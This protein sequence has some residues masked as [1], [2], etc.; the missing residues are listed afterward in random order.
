MVSSS[1]AASLTVRAIGPV[2]ASEAHDGGK[3]PGARNRGANGSLVERSR[4]RLRLQIRGDKDRNVARANGAPFAGSPV[5]DVGGVGVCQKPRH[6]IR[7]G[8]RCVVAV[9][10]VEP[11]EPERWQIA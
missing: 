5:D 7:D 4:N 2:C 1:S 11:K 9:L 10:G 6:A 3:K 8:E